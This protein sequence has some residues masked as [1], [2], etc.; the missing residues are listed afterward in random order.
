MAD[1]Q[2]QLSA[3]LVEFLGAKEKIV[4]LS[5][6]DHEE[7]VPATTSISWVCAVSPTKIR[8]AIDPRSRV[9]KNIEGN[10]RLTL[11]F[12]GL[13]SSFSV[14][15]SGSS[16]LQ[17]LDGVTIRMTEVEVDVVSVREIMYYGSKVTTEPQMEKT[18][19]LALAEKLDHAVYAAIGRDE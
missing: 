12:I 7:G 1:I 15:G 13:G 5:T 3:E 6:I 11:S 10:P 4:F 9:I 18:Y 16:H 19:N 14:S 8:F 17:Q 2:Q